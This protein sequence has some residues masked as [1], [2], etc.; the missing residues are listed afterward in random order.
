MKKTQAV[1]PALLQTA[2]AA[3]SLTDKPGKT[4]TI[5]I[6]IYSSRLAAQTWNGPA[7]VSRVLE[8]KAIISEIVV[9]KF[10]VFNR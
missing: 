10:D 5:V 2:R 9:F 1:S 4:V 7:I 3:S 6:I 8:V